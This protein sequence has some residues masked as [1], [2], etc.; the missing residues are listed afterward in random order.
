MPMVGGGDD[1]GV[2]VIAAGYFAKI[3]AGGAIG[4]LVTFVDDAFGLVAMGFVHVAY[5]D[6][7]H[8][9]LSKKAVHVSAALAA[10]ADDAHDNPFAGG[11]RAVRA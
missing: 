7:L 10:R 4:V 6:D 9:S 8:V 3:V 2:D 11:R 5:R 1:H